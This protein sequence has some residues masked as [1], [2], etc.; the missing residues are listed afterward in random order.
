MPVAGCWPARGLRLIALRPR[1]PARLRADVDL[2]RLVERG[3]PDPQPFDPGDVRIVRHQVS[4]ETVEVVHGPQPP[5]PDPVAKAIPV[6][7]AYRLKEDHLG[8]R[9]G[10][11]AV[12]GGREDVWHLLECV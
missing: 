10:E 12:D 6:E 2:D 4:V 11:H 1:R 7:L 9:E 8:P 5:S 3:Q